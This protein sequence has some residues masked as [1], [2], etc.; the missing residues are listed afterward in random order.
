LWRSNWRERE[1]RALEDAIIA[2]NCQLGIPAVRILS[3][4]RML[5]GCSDV[6]RD[7]V[8]MSLAQAI[9]DDAHTVEHLAQQYT[10]FSEHVMAGRTSEAIETMRSI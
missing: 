7:E 5:R 1:L 10:C 2:F 4:I 3:H 8:A 9:N 6:T